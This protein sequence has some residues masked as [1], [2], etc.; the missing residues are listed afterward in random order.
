MALDISL[1]IETLG[2]KP[3]CVILS[4]GA[5]MFEPLAKDSY[6]AE[7]Y[8]FYR[9]ITIFDQLMAGLAIDQ[10]TVEWWRDKDDAMTALIKPAPISLQSALTDLNE[11]IISF[12][13][14]GNVWAKSPQFDCSI[15]EHAAELYAIKPAWNFR[16]LRDVRTIHAASLAVGRASNPPSP[17]GITHNALS[18]AMHQAVLVQHAFASLSNG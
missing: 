8:Q 15:I 6:F 9:N 18:D 1:D 17:V 11:W 13:W 3:G 16:D 4:I 5:V 2:K 10:E 12:E 7:D 14:S